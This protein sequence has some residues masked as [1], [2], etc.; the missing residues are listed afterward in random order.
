[1]ITFHEFL[2][3]PEFGFEF[4]VDTD[5]DAYGDMLAAVIAFPM[6][7]FAACPT[8]AATRAL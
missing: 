2:R 6:P 3:D 1:M 5:D 8:R 7:A 4:P